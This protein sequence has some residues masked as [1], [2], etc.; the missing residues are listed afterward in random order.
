MNL[1]IKHLD[2]NWLQ[3]ILVYNSSLSCPSESREDG[4]SSLSA[5][6]CQ[7]IY[8]AT[9]FKNRLMRFTR[10]SQ[11]GAGSW[12]LSSFI[13]VALGMNDSWPSYTEQRMF[14]RSAVLLSLTFTERMLQL[15]ASSSHLA[16]SAQLSTLHKWLRWVFFSQENV[17]KG[18]NKLCNVIDTVNT[19]PQ[20]LKALLRL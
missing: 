7:C 5:P 9:S 6:Y 14:S 13:E 17:R 19:Y 4:P 15:H 18:L 3:V 11:S 16:H 20:K 12:W 10:Q 1:L 8:D 2:L